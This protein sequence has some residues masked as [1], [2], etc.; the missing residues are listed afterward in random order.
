MSIVVEAVVMWANVERLS[1][2]LVDILR[3]FNILAFPQFASFFNTFF[4]SI[5]W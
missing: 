1:N 4:N 5:L 3:L 2:G